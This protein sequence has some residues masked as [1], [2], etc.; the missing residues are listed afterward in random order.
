MQN[1]TDAADTFD[2]SFDTERKGDH[3]IRRAV[4]RHDQQCLRPIGHESDEPGYY[5]GTRVVG[6][7]DERVELR[8][9]HGRTHAVQPRIEH[10][11]RQFHRRARNQAAAHLVLIPYAATSNSW[12]GVLHNTSA[13]PSVTTMASPSTM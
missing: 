11:I 8:I 1:L 6:V 2:P 12:R 13:P 4:A 3:Q 5:R 9:A 10:R 7:D